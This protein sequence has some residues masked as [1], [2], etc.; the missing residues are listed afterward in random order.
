MK[1][2]QTATYGQLAGMAGSPGAARAVGSIMAANR[3]PLI[4]GCHRI[5]RADGKIGN[6]SFCGSETKKKMLELEKEIQK[7]KFKK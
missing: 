1:I 6:F 4:V 7:S 2:G 3:W 5:I